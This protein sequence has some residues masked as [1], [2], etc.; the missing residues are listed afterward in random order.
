M[1]F[2]RAK[3]DDL[4]RE[5]ERLQLIVSKL[6]KEGVKTPSKQSALET[7][8]KSHKQTLDKFHRSLE[9]SSL[10]AVTIDLDGVIKFCND[11]LC[12]ATGYT[13]K[14]IM[15]KSIFGFLLPMEMKDLYVSTY[16]RFIEKGDF[17]ENLNDRLIHKSKRWAYIR[18]LS[19]ILNNPYDPLSNITIVA[20]DVTEMARVTKALEKSN[21][22][23]QELFD[24]A[25]DLILVISIDGKFK[26]YNQ[27]WMEAVGYTHEEL[28]NLRLED[29]LHPDY[30]VHTENFLKHLSFTERSG[31]LETVVKSKSGQ[32]IFLTG[33]VNCSFEK[34]IPVEFRTIFHDIS[35]RVRTEKIRNLYYGIAN[36]SIH[37]HSFEDLYKNIHSELN[38]FIDA[39]NFYFAILE[40]DKLTFPFYVKDNKKKPYND[41]GFEK[42]VTAYALSQNQSLLISKQDFKS[43]QKQGML[44]EMD[45]LPTI[46]LGAPLAIEQHKLGLISLY[47][48]NESAPFDRSDLDLLDFISGQ[49]SLAISRKRNE[50]KITNQTGRLNAIFESSS[51]LIWSV[52]TNFEYTSFN[53]NYSDTVYR[54]S[55][56]RPKPNKR[57]TAHINLPTKIDQE[58]FWIEKYQEVF[59]GNSVHFETQYEGSF[60]NEIWFDIY[61]NPIYTANNTVKEVSGIAHDVTD[62]KRS[63]LALRESEDKFRNILESFQDLYFKCTPQ[64]NILMVSPS[65][66]EMTGYDQHEVL[67]KNITNYYLYTSKTK[68]LLRQLVQHRR[69]RNFEASLVRK[70]GKIIQCICNVRLKADNEGS[71][72]V[73]GVIRDI[74]K[75]KETNEQLVQAIEVAE[76]S[77]RVKEE[78]LANMSHE[79]RTPMNGIIG[80]L[81]LLSS[82]GL[83]P[84]Q[85]E[86]LDTIKKSSGL[87]MEILN[88]ILTC[89]KLKRAK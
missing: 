35:E 82:T 75:L 74:T 41:Q 54:Y 84:Q 1:S 86:Y 33:S 36:Q 51:H 6:Q 81:D 26:F 69:V 47:S 38:I 20:E 29:L 23:L 32:N 66:L 45:N 61:L 49:I 4:I 3:K 65:V 57:L 60:G 43:L 34:E 5:I 12:L 27:S 31:K 76:R 88:D 28:T 19:F 73:E 89:Q 80:M 7:I 58:N 72:E 24:N 64:G 56:V 44:P 37:S 63:G 11:A 9:K 78:F 39:K 55:G 46:W 77:L 48:Y 10:L 53:Q 2:D 15:E 30:R 70:D 8:G 83:K 25:H 17:P 68:G 40:D 14:E 67:E 59:E 71:L 79:I 52:D 50:D 21:S 87:L 42:Q 13:Q 22:R 85:T 18:Y 16:K 62:K